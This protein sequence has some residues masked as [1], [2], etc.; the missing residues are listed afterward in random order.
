[1]TN[2]KKPSIDQKLRIVVVHAHYR[3]RG[4]ED[5]VFANECALLEADGHTVIR[6]EKTND[7]IHEG[8]LIAKL[9]LLRNTI[10]NPET[11][12]EI[13]AL[14]DRERPDLVHCH[15]TFPT[16]SPS[17]FWACSKKGVPVVLT[18]H[19]FRT[20][21]LNGY[22]FRED[23]GAVCERC[24]GRAPIPGV[25]RKCYR[26]SFLASFVV[27][28]RLLFHR[29]IGTYRKKVSA[30]IA[31]TESGKRIFIRAG[32]PKEKIHVKA[33]LI[34]ERTQTKLDELPADDCSV[35][36]PFILYAGRLSPEKGP[37]IALDA[38]LRMNP[39][40]N[41]SLVFAG[42]GPMRSALQT[43]AAESPYGA[44]IRFLGHV[45]QDEL[46][47][48]MAR[49]SAVV[50]PSKLYETFQ[51]SAV[52]AN[53]LKT[54]VLLSDVVCIAPEILANRAGQTFPNK[55]TDALAQLFTQ[56]LEAPHRTIP[57]TM[58]PECDPD[59]NLTRLLDIYGM[60]LP[61][62]KQD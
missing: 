27:A 37:D 17:V 40:P 35:Q 33:N 12:R 4:G 45:P 48:L 26:G 15:N 57:G 7:D 16:I 41:T 6:Y 31:L 51:L 47:D 22:L 10:W 23:T 21:C 36:P 56:T 44:S 5:S 29:L 62:P 42:D 14:I 20:A 24:L 19:N 60:V 38:W 39:I 61:K 43:R 49:A 3:I 59:A 30:F 54:P 28:A 2:Q 25:C 58:F 9:R 13:S 53:R 32:L 18:L 52:E 50:V 55:D 34:P 46:H 8:G 11:V 1:M